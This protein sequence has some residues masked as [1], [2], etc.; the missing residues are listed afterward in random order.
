[1]AKDGCGL[2]GVQSEGSGSQR[3]GRVAET[4]ARSSWRAVSLSA[5]RRGLS[6][7]VGPAGG[8]HLSRRVG[9]AGSPDPRLCPR[10][11]SNRSVW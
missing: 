1:M 4:R 7:G 2:D 10:G 5:G 9:R 6:L 3:L 8:P 11:Y